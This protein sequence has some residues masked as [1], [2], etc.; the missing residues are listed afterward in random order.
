MSKNKNKTKDKTVR[1]GLFY[2]SNGR[3]TTTPYLGVTYTAYQVSRN[4]LKKDISVL[5]NQV[6]K[7]KTRLLPVKV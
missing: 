7:S 3:W 5:K 2:R 6:L 1:Y 4:P